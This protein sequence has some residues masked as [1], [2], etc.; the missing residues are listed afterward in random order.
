VDSGRPDIDID[1]FS[2]FLPTVHP[3]VTHMTLYASS[4]DNAL[5]A[6]MSASEGKQRAGFVLNGEPVVASGV[7]SVHISALGR[8][9][10]P[11]HDVFATNRS[12]IDD[13]RLV[14]RRVTRLRN[15]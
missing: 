15:V 8:D 3:Y 4:Q 11:N 2:E 10:R 7:D 5:L 6:S 12:L 13:I 9:F 1:Q 14:F